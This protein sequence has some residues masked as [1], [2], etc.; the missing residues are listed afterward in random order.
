M[1][2]PLRL[3]ATPFISSQRRT[4]PTL[5]GAI[6]TLPLSVNLLVLSWPRRRLLLILE[7]VPRKLSS[8][9]PL[10]IAPPH[11]SM[12]SIILNTMLLR[13]SSPMPLA[14]PT[15]LPQLLRCL[16]R[17]S[18]LLR[19]SWLPSTPPPHLNSLS[20][21]LPRVEKTG[22]LEELPAITLSPLLLV[23]PRLSVS[24]SQNSRA[25][26]LVCPSEFPPSTYPL[27]ISLLSSRSLP[28]ML[29]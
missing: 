14:Q 8:L 24:S 27:L 2:K 11:M 20:M 19:V 17:N 13:T 1:T 9:L 5:S 7:V 26:S 25:N 4:P 6:T 22:E 21:D 15:A 10:R 18:E 23:L 28:L 3:M 16:M 29:T 12:V